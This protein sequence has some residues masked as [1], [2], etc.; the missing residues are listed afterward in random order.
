M[1][2]LVPA[3]FPVHAAKLGVRLVCKTNNSSNSRQ[4]GSNDQTS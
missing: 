3:P 2:P 1:V 4:G